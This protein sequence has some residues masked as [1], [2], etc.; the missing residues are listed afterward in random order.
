MGKAAGRKRPNAAKNEVVPKGAA[1]MPW[2]SL[3]RLIKAH[4]MEK[5]GKSKYRL[6]AARLRKEGKSIREISRILCVAYSTVRDRLV[7]MHA[8][9]LSRRFDRRGRGRARILT[10]RIPRKIKR[11]LGRDPSRYG[12]EAGSWQMIMIQDM[13][14]KKFRTRC[15]TGTLRRA[16]RRFRFSYRKPRPVP[17]NSAT[18][19][20][21]ERF[22]AETNLVVN[23]AAEDGFTVL[24]CDEM[25]A[26]LWSDAGYRWRPTNGHDTIKTSYS[27]KS[28][29]V[30]GV[31]GLDSI[32]IRTVNAC[33][34]ETFKGFLRAMLC[35][36]P[37]ILLILDNAPSQVG[38]RHR[39][40]Q[41]QRGPAQTGVPARLHP[42]AQP[43][44]AAVERPQ[45]GDARGQV[46]CV[47][48]RSEGGHRGHHPR[49]PDVPRRDGGLSGGRAITKMIPREGDWARPAE[50]PAGT[51]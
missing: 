41:G 32:H 46:F 49:P 17:Y 51:P 24:S 26:H 16:L 7:R 37:K 29:S 22:K 42:A 14:Y 8:G 20:E 13:L 6:H 10:R 25:H 44:R 18:P 15:K 2:L 21:Q 31:L 47:G 12:C 50:N 45:E 9:N 1:F 48:R 28:V 30:F 11:W 38:N 36:H 43:D 3:K 33:N 40:R 4:E 23:E 27:K 5:A 19:E 34:S 35:I 39:V